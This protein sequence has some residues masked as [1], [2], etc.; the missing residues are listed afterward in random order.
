MERNLDNRV[1]AVTP[2]HD[3]ALQ[4]QLREILDTCL[5]DN[6][7]CWEMH[8]DGSY[9]QRT[10]EGEESVCAQQRFMEQARAEI[11]DLED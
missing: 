6:Q 3:R 2:I 4:T 9:S 5:A 1:E 11:Q 10:P 7:N 8:S